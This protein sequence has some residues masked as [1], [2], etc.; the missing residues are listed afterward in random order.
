MAQLDLSFRQPDTPPGHVV[1]F[2][3]PPD[4][5]DGLGHINN[6]AY[7]R[8]FERVA[9]DHSCCLGLDLDAYRRLDRAMVVRRHE[10]DY[11]T[12]GFIGESLQAQTWITYNDGKASLARA[13]RLVRQSDGLILARCATSYTCV[14]L[15]TGK[16]KRMPDDFVSKYKTN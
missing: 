16:V 14:A 8:Y 5:I 1:D 15:S 2:T 13:F 11:L 3:V 12:P 9:W 10:L 4:D 7:L 6:V